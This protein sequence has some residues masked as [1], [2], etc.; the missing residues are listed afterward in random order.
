M[1]NFWVGLHR[2]PDGGNAWSLP[3]PPPPPSRGAEG[4]FE[5]AGTW[6]GKACERESVGGAERACKSGRPTLPR[7][8]RPVVPAARVADA[9]KERAR[10]STGGRAER[11]IA[12][13]RSHGFSH[14]HT[15]HIHTHTYT[16][17]IH[18][19]MR[20]VSTKNT[21]T[22]STH[23]YNIDLFCAYVDIHTVYVRVYLCL[24][25][26]RSRLVCGAGTEGVRVQ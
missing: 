9:R 10:A 16:H 2:S 18:V 12:G 26:G 20:C 14:I 11:T 24:S 17:A 19:C 6:R 3:N 25:G 4:S 1:D 13:L 21:Y 23:I 7:W 5:G 8:A 22:Y 15:S